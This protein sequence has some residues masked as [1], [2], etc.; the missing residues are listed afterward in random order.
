MMLI[1]L[2]LLVL[3][4]RNLMILN[5][6]VEFQCF[7]RLLLDPLALPEDIHLLVSAFLAQFG[8]GL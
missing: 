5:I 2:C 1:I 3:V 6:L 8:L 7:L 4:D